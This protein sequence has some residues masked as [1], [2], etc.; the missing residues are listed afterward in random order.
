MYVWRNIFLLVK[1][2]TNNNNTR[3][4]HEK[5]RIFPTIDGHKS[6]LA[7]YHRMFHII[8][9]NTEPNNLQVTKIQH[10][11]MNV[12]CHETYRFCISYTATNECWIVD[13]AHVTMVHQD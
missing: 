3:Q 12:C 13:G 6:I 8:K 5:I 4:T 10:L 7:Q 11:L 1:I 2:K 9:L